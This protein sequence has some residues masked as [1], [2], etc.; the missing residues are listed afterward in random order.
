MNSTQGA[1][2]GLLRRGP[3]T[4]HQL[5]RQAAQEIG[6][7]WSV[8]RS[9]VYRELAALADQ[10]LVSTSGA[11]GSGGRRE[12]A[13]TEPG[14]QAFLGW[15]AAEPEAEQL[16]VPLLL[17]LTFIDDLEP[18][19]LQRLLDSQRAAHSARLQ[20]YQASL[21][22]WRAEA[23]PERYLLPLA[24]GI[25]YEQAVLDWFAELPDL[26]GSAGGSDDRT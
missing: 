17:R 25:R 11:T 18:G 14:R 19:Q 24:Y 7:Y 13:L 22:G 6:D 26:P 21:D 1:L 4:A 12:Y 20:E 10:G 15:L 3:A 23:T 16:R 8:T 9:Q 5:A 2:L